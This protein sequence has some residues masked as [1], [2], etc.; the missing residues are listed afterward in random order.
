MH[1]LGAVHQRACMGGGQCM[2]V[3]GSINGLAVLQGLHESRAMHGCM[4]TF[5]CLRLCRLVQ[6]AVVWS[7]HTTD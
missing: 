7:L 4:C 5:E 6:L 3:H 2:C 1:E